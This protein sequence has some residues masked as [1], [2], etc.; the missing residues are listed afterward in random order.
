MKFYIC[1]KCKIFGVVDVCQWKA[2]TFLMNILY[3]MSEIWKK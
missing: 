2:D 1:H 3:K